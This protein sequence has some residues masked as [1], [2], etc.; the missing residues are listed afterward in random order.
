VVYSKD[1]KTV[2]AYPQDKQDTSYTLPEGLT[3][4]G[5]YAFSGSESL[6]SITLPASLTSIG[7]VAFLECVK[8][9]SVYISNSAQAAYEWPQGVK[10]IKS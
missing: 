8:L 10:V 1:Q 2:L 4:I 7:N 5:E 3:G 6:S 9:S